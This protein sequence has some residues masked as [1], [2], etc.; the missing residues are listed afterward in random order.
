MRRAA[1]AID[2]GLLF[3]SADRSSESVFP[4]LGVRENMTLQV[5][6]RFAGAGLV[7][8]RKRAGEAR[9]WCANTAW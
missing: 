9:G 8:A 5:L 6:D 2:G 4:E 3:L 7:S 1:R